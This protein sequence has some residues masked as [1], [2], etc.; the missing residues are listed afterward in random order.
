[1]SAYLNMKNPSKLSAPE[2]V[3]PGAMALMMLAFGLNPHLAAA[4]DVPTAP[5]TIPSE[6]DS[7]WKISTSAYVWATGLSGTLRTLPP[8]P[9]V[10]IDIGF[11]DVLKNLDV[12]FM[13]AA[14]ARNGRIVLFS[15]VIISKISL[16]KSFTPAG[17]PASVKVGST[18]LIGLA[19]AGYRIVDSANFTLDGLVGLR[20]FS[21]NNK[22][23]VQILPVALNYAKSQSWVDGVVGAKMRYNFTPNLYA[24]A[25]GFVGGLSS[26]F[27]WDAFAGVGYQISDKWNAFAG[28]RALKVDYRRG[29]FVYN[30]LQQGPIL[31][32]SYKF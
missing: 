3:K 23:Q 17:Y 24:T 25:I 20:G 2:L 19:A 5:V 29:N 15:D 13:G 22:I 11:K 8:L 4:A 6:T 14:E 9:A 26:K 18:S 10:H 12:A 28:Y 27:E 21:V 31:G 30:A 16:G 1:M 7:A 32:A